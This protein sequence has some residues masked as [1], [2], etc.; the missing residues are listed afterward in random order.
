MRFMCCSTSG[1][2]VYRYLLSGDCKRPYR[3]RS[4]SARYSHLGLCEFL[5]ARKCSMDTLLKGRHRMAGINL[6]RIILTKTCG[7]D[8]HCVWPYTT[9]A[10]G[11]VAVGILVACV[12]TFGPVFHPQRFGHRAIVRRR[13]DSRKD[14][15]AARGRPP[16]RNL[17]TVSDATMSMSDQEPSRTQ[18]D[19]DVSLTNTSE[20]KQGSPVHAVELHTIGGL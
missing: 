13:E 14:L 17:L 4:A 7:Q 11:E 12:P 2:F 10:G 15:L 19:I 20:S 5:S 6:C 3:R 9:L 16:S 18:S 8:L 1:L